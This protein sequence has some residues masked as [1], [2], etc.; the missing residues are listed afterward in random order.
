MIVGYRTDT[1]Q[2]D[3]IEQRARDLKFKNKSGYLKSLVD[4]DLGR[5]KQEPSGHGQLA[6]NIRELRE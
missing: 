6:R 3:A 5:Y 4:K 1:E 2:N